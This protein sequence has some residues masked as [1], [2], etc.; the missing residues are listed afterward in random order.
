MD[1]GPTYAEA[2]VDIDAC[3]R[4]LER[5]LGWVSRT[6]AFRPERGRSALPIGHF[7]NVVDIGHGMGLAVSTDGVGTKILIAEMLDKYSWRSQSPLLVS[8]A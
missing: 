6:A 2:G 5:M 4:A 7:A 3:G 1:G 8:A